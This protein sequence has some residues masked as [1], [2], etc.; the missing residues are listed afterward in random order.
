MPE[1]AV[2]VVGMGAASTSFERVRGRAPPPFSPV[3]DVLFGM[4]VPWVVP[5]ARLST[6]ELDS[7]A[8]PFTLLKIK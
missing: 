7:L 8:S 1:G 2:E 4:G 6:A 5:L 3:V